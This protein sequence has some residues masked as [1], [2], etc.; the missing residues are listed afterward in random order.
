MLQLLAFYEQAST[1]VK[2]YWEISKKHIRTYIGPAPLAYIL[3][4][5]G[6][7]LPAT[8]PLPDTVKNTAY[9]YNPESNR[10]TL[11]NNTIPEGRFRPLP[12]LSSGIRAPGFPDIDVSD[13]LS[14]LRANPVPS[15]ELKQVILLWSLIYNVYVPMI[16]GTVITA[17]TNDGV[18]TSTTL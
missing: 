15:L 3:T 6:Q 4:N 7:V 1:V 16:P 13:W 18:E 10:I 2:F 11:A 9:L 8:M 5:D 14:E 17:T 12:F